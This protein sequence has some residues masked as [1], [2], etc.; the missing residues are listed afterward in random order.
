MVVPSWQYIRLQCQPRVAA[1]RLFIHASPTNR[2]AALRGSHIAARACWILICD[3]CSLVP[4]ANI[5][6]GSGQGT[7]SDV[8]SV[9][10]R[11]DGGLIF[12]NGFFSGT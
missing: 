1:L 6:M 10:T 12:V 8:M 3:C 2:Y 7:T 4:V 11:A 9:F 5:G